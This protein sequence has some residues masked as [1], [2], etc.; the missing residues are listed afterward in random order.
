MTKVRMTNDKEER[1]LLLCHF[2]FWNL[3]LTLSL[4][5]LL[6]R[7]NDVDPPF[8]ADNLAVLANPFYAGADFHRRLGRA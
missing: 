8:A 2:A 6:I 5:V 1:T 4:F 7:A 3:S